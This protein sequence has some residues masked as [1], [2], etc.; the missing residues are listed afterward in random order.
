[1]PRTSKQ[2]RLLNLVSFLLKVRRPVPWEEI[3]DGME[4]YADASQ[5]KET[6]LRRFERDK[7]DLRRMGILVQFE[8]LDTPGGG[9]YRIPRDEVFL[10][11]IEL[12][13]EEA[14]TLAVLGRMARAGGASPL[15]GA[16][17][18]ALQKL[19]FDSP[20]AGGVQ[21]TMEERFIFRRAD[22]DTPSAEQDNLG[23]LTEAAI[24][25]RTV[26]FTYYAIGPDRTAE[27]T[28]DPYGLG[29][30]GGKWYLVGWCHSRRAIRSFRVD[31]IRGEVALARPNA[32]GP[33]FTAPETFRLEDYLGRPPWRFGRA[34]AVTARTRFDPV[35]AWMVK[36]ARAAGERWSDEPDGGGV[37]EQPVTNAAA[38]LQWVL[39][40][41]RHATVLELPELRQMTVDALK[42]TRALY[43]A[44]EAGHA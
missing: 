29:A 33:D 1:M 9:G 13:P 41:G 32:A 44:G 15:A 30:E 8:P 16:L 42:A 43:A 38:F 7:A 21:S 23:R 37:L 19:Q 34:K 2:E 5:P 40:F 4:D 6:A 18:S 10:P 12:S 26:R 27:R 25:S 11:R 17:S 39:R 3:R 35:V 28:V 22:A 20:G 24:S 31:R 36:D 14:A